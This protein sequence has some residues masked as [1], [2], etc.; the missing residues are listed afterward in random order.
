MNLYSA[1][2]GAEKEKDSVPFYIARY[3]T[4]CIIPLREDNLNGCPLNSSF[5]VFCAWYAG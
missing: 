1:R 5:F 3:V 4:G 2:K